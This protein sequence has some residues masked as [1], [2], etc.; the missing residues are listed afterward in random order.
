MGCVRFL[1]LE[2]FY[3]RLCKDS[4]CNDPK[5]VLGSNVKGPNNKFVES[6][7]KG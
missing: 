6:G 5:L 2:N 1:S 7:L 4:T 3:N